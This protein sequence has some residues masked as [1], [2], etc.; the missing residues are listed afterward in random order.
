VLD[1]T[2]AMARLMDGCQRSRNDAK[3][4]CRSCSS[5]ARSAGALFHDIGYLRKR[6]DHRHRIWRR[7]YDHARR[8]R[9]HVPAPVRAEL[10]LEKREAQ[11][12]CDAAALHRLRSQ[13]AVDP[14]R[15]G[16]CRGA[17]V[18]FSH[19]DIIARCRPLYLE[20]CRD[21]PVSGIRARQSREGASLPCRVVLPRLVAKTP[22]FYEGATGRLEGQLG[23]T[24][25]YAARYFGGPKTSTS[26][27]CART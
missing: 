18:S 2:L 7:I 8:A 1:V 21:R 4:W 26:M 10:G 25:E 9:R 14:H 17:S 19:G 22:G 27:G 13:T 12:C 5:S 6:N 16:G 3:R 20:K 11:A 15:R 24:Y 23:R